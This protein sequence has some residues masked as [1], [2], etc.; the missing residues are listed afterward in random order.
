M[1]CDTILIIC[2]LVVVPLLVILI[3]IVIDRMK[4]ALPN[5]KQN[6]EYIKI[7]DKELRESFIKDYINSN[8]CVWVK[9]NS[10]PKSF[11]IGNVYFDKCFN[12]LEYYQEFLSYVV[13]DRKVYDNGSLNIDFGF[14][15][16]YRTINRDL[17]DYILD[18][19]DKVEEVKQ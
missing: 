15:F 12:N 7:S 1:L 4:I 6:D 19:L 18:N 5:S 11:K 14:D 17:M 2:L 13:I 8:C 3:F 16:Y 9:I 10:L